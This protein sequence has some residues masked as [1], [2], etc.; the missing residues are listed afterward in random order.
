MRVPHQ[1]FIRYENW[2]EQ[3]LRD[4]EVISSRDVDKL[5]QEISSLYPQ[6]EE[7]LLKA[8]ISMYVGGYEKRVEDPEVRYWTNWAGIKTYKTFNCFP[9]LSDIE[10]AFVFYAIGKVFVPL[11]LHERGVK[12]ESFKSL[13]PEDQ[14]KVVKEELEV[15]WENHLIRVLQILPFLGLSSTSI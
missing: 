11:L 13:S 15:I 9:Q 10:L 3:F 4:Y 5:A 12:S 6:R 2:K 1:E 14:E 8:L 7:R